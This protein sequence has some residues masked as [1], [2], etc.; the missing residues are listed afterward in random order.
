M[1]IWFGFIVIVVVGLLTCY[2]CLSISFPLPPPPPYKTQ[3]FEQRLDHFNY[4]ANVNGQRTYKE[5]YL[6]ADK[7]WGTKSNL[8]PKKA[9]CK[10]PIFF[11]TGNESPVTD[12]YSGSGFFTQVKREKLF[13]LKQKKI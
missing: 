7:Y 4:E 5:R 11:Y 1:K 3:Y 2:Q 8:Y 12:Y 9:N 6:I 13:L 10:G